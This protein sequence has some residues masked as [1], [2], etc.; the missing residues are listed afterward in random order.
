MDAI[1][2][3]QPA[4]SGVSATR[5]AH[6]AGPLVTEGGKMLKNRNLRTNA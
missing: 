1:Q 6:I 3:A 2:T 4:Q 5:Q